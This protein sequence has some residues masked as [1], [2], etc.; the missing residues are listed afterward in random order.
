MNDILK[1][2]SAFTDDD[3]L[4][5]PNSL[6]SITKQ[7]KT[8]PIDRNKVVYKFINNM[9][10]S[11]PVGKVI[12]ELIQQDLNIKTDSDKYEKFLKYVPLMTT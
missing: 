7:N 12:H 3:Q 10:D 11:N 9:I 2:P 1:Q 6:S 8:G 4:D 5:V